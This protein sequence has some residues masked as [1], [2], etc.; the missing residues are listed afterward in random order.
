MNRRAEPGFVEVHLEAEGRP[1]GFLCDSEGNTL[2]TLDFSEC[3]C[4]EHSEGRCLMAKVEWEADPI[5]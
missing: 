5:A 3:D 1:L 4:G 2:A